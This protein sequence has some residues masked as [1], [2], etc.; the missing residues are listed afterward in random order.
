M[1]K[2]NSDYETNKLSILS[3]YINTRQEEFQQFND[4]ME[5]HIPRYLDVAG[6]LWEY[7]INKREGKPTLLIIPGNFGTYDTTFFLINDLKE[8]FQIICPSFPSPVTSSDAFFQGINAILAHENITK[9][10]ILGRS[11]GGLK[12]LCYAYSYP[13]RISKLVISQGFPPYPEQI[14]KLKKIHQALKILPLDAIVLPMLRLFFKVI[15]KKQFTRMLTAHSIAP[16]FWIKY[17]ERLYFHRNSGE[18]IRNSCQCLIDFCSKFEFGQTSFQNWSKE[19]LL[20]VADQ[21]EE[22]IYFEPH[23]NSIKDFFPEARIHT[24]HGLGHKAHII[25]REEHSNTIRDFLK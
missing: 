6:I 10:H 19:T 7:I 11:V 3:N 23:R 18:R 15:L 17:L 14:Q 5:H 16:Q 8:D 20:I 1:E 21:D 2:I 9:I 12:A 13:D 24:F 4:F 22:T 25:K